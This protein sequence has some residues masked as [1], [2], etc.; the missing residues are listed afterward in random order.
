HL[1]DMMAR[2]L[3]YLYEGDGA[4]ALLEI[5][6]SWPSLE[7]SLLLR[8]EM[9]RIQSLLL[10][11]LS[12]LVASR[13]MSEG[14]EKLRQAE[15]DAR[16]LEKERQPFAAGHALLVRAGIALRRGN[17]EQAVALYT[18]AAATFSELEMELHAA[19]ARRRKGEILGGAE[20]AALV[21]DS[22]EW[23]I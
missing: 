13:Q 10:R 17:A 14:E 18:A 1:C 21:R 9:P 20:G 5:E 11:A 15:R 2:A 4:Q 16:A 3:S 23:M 19:A 6:A 22:A 7:R 12:A 8:G